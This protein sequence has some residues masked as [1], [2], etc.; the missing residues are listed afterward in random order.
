MV[1]VFG[2]RD[3]V[4]QPTVRVIVGEQES[5][6]F[7]KSN[8]TKEPRNPPESDVFVPISMCLLSKTTQ[9][10]ALS[11]PNGRVWKLSDSPKAFVN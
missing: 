9:T 1:L 8:R 10:F 3:G 5:V 2:A 11:D 4:V 6:V 7:M